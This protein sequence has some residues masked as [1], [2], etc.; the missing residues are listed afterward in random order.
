MENPVLEPRSERIARYKAE[1]RREL[2]ERFGNMEEL[3][4]KWVRRDGKEVHDPAT[5]AHRGNLNSDGLS[6]RVNGRARGVTNGLEDPAESNNLRRQG[7]PDSASMLS[8]EGHLVPL[9]LDSPQL[10]TR[11]SVG[12]LR[13][14]LLQQTGSGAQ[15][16]KVCPDAGRATS[17]LDLAVKPGSD[18]GRRRTRRYLPGG[19]GG[20]RKTSER[21]RTQPITANEMEES[22]GL[23]DAEEE[24]NCKADVKTDD[25]AKMSVAAKM[26]L[27]KELEKSA[28]PEA[29]VFLKPRS[30]SVSHERRVRRG[31]DHRFLT[32]PI[33]CEEI[34]AISA[35]KPAP[36][37]ES[38]SVQAES[39]EDADENCKLSM[40]EKL[41]LFNKLSLPGRQGGSPADGPPERRRQ[42]GARYRTQ[43]ITVEEVNLL[44]EGPVQLPAFY[45]SP[46][47]SD[48]Q[49]ASSVNLKPS[50]IR[51]SKPRPDTGLVPGEPSCPTQQGQQGLQRHD[52]EP[53][54]RG[55]L[56]KSCSGG[57]EWSRT[58]GG[59]T[60]T[61][62]SHEQNG[63]GCE[64]AG[65]QGRRENTEQQEMSA[66]P[67]RER[68][69]ASGVEG[70]S[71]TAAPWRQRARTRRETIACT[72]IRAL[73]EQDAPQEER[74]CQMKLQEQLVP[75]VEHSSDT[76]G[77]VQ[78]Q[79][80]E[81][82][83]RRMNEETH[84]M[85][86]IQVTLADDTVKLQ[87]TTNTS[88]I[89]E[90]TENLY[91]ES[92]NPQ[93]WEP[94]FASVYSSSTP[95]YIMCFNQTNLSFEAQEVSSPT[96]NQIQP[97]KSKEVDDK[98]DQVE[99]LNTEQ[100]RK[101]QEAGCMAKREISMQTGIEFED[102]Q[103][104]A[105]SAAPHEVKEETPVDES[106]TF[107]AGFYS[108]QPSPSA[109]APPPSGD[110][111]A[112]ESE[113]DLGVLCQTNTPILTSAVAEHRRS[114][115][116]SRRTQG[117]RNP[118]RALAAR[119]D[120]RQ[121]Y[122]GERVNTAAEESTQAEKKSK[123]SSVADSHLSRSEDL[124]SSSDA[125]KSSPP[126]SSLMLIHIKGRRHVQ[127]RLVEPSA[128]SLNSGDC[129][130]L[131]TPEHCI[132][133]S[134]EF[135]NEQEKAKA[136]ELASSIQSQRDLGCQAPQMVHLEEGLNCDSSLAADFWSLLG[137]RTQ[138]R[139]ASAEEEDEIY[140]RG[141]VESN[142]V[143][144][145][146]ENKL[147]PHE[148][149]WASIP[150]ITLL[151]SNEALAFD[152][153][154]EVYLWHGQDVSLSRKNV[155]LQLT[156]QVWVGAYD[157]TNCRVNPLDPT[158]C[159][160]NTQLRGEGR[161]SWALFG[162]VSEHSETALFREKFLD[163]TGRSGGMEEAAAVSKKTQPIPVQSSQSVSL[164]PDVLSACDAKALV[165]GQ[166]LEGDSLVHNVLGG[167]DVQRGHG[168]ITLEGGRQME[169][170]TVAVDTW[171]VQEFDDSEIPVESTGQLYEGD[172]YVIRWTY[173][174]NTVDEMNSTDERSRGPG[175]KEYSA[176]FLWRGRDSS[177]S[178]RDTAAFLSIGINNHEDS[179]VL[180]PQGKEPPCF[181]QLFQGGLAIH[182]GKREE[183][184]TNAAEW[185][186]FCVRGQLPEEGSLLEVDCCCAGL[187]SR[188]SVVLLNSQQGILYLWT[189]CK[190]P[191]SSRV[192]SKRAVEHLTQM[193]PLEL[194]LSK[195]SPVTVQVVE[196]GS[197]P[198]DFWTALG[199]MDR[200]AYDC[201]LQDPG[202]YN[203]TPRLFHL[204]ASSGS[205][206][207]EELLS[208]TRLPGLVMAMP[209]VQE[210]LYS[211]PQPAL[212]LLD[213]R[214][215]VYL[216]QRGQ[217]EQ[218]ESS[219]SA[220]GCWH[221][222]RRCAMQMALQY[223]KEMNPRRP[224]Q[225]YLIFEGLEPL[226]FTNVFPRWE[227]SLGPHT[228]GDAGRVKLTLVQDALAQL[229]KTQYPLEELLRS[230]LPEGVDPQRLEVY[231][232]DQDF[233][234]ILEMKRDE[235][236]SLPDWKQIDLKKS[237]GLLC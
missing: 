64:E 123:N 87:E 228:Q 128:R 212:F 207:A 46:H 7:S 199:Q 195:S 26:S 38:Q 33:T 126:F 140:E 59:Q 183:P 122:M 235:Y 202:K 95:Q 137:G 229:M 42:K 186:L 73:S 234:T 82:S 145:L 84:A 110:V 181:L 131:V 21:F 190:A 23:L 197:E 173:S 151:G 176:F 88:R 127:V 155:A 164:S 70:G 107:D 61:P 193:C 36:T 104:S 80:E 81:E 43:P 215:E 101:N 2:A 121:D 22:H 135:A 184:S 201:M 231:L 206:Q 109:C 185:R 18:G 167:V 20:G 96:K 218:T 130:L 118:L 12:Q 225:A 106:N 51:L 192:V 45:L 16:E 34:V 69:K 108:D 134:G 5:Q 31:N 204:S 8:G 222:E 24:E 99:E 144:R 35:P 124:I 178:G 158:Q 19:L 216:W 66:A 52:S 79:N 113:Q 116:P 85:G 37:V 120:I 142:C 196:E 224:P 50:E 172:S 162:C 86:H 100:K 77:R 138:Y 157:Y 187:R 217:P 175:Q 182:K 220:W 152:F 90:G 147:V 226:T 76:T 29:S 3:P 83:V 41:A 223:C 117:S 6:E 67:R 94:V 166:S 58:D 150:S 209:F 62:T 40:S 136:S 191:S 25:R 119:D 230:P 154:S 44:Q 180:V 53:V 237:K 48:R 1:R 102:P 47:L 214:L 233:Q 97:Q 10:H 49:Q 132:L 200:K 92:V 203:F 32:Q 63:G 111:A 11:V 57:S 169:L 39:V 78:K 89:K 211:V 160:P 163:W 71:L 153:G 55:I 14:A 114:V 115:R 15:P 28:A 159:N 174:T 74:P 208:P 194:G 60:D 105:L 213:N 143:Y 98:M 219:A 68:R 179:Q 161:P 75:S 27:F 236:D 91:V 125:T 133:W 9:G 156:H 148:Q 30:G 13:S 189:G 177:V 205:F 168:V 227:R 141:V 93:C 171:H 56:K 54:L 165:S 146:V 103:S 129:F 72:P 232:S 139:G 17:S 149:A 198:A 221:D 188:G 170:K 65:I 112:A 210:S 4:S